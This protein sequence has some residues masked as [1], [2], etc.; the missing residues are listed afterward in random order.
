M[1]IFRGNHWSQMPNREETIRKDVVMALTAAELQ[2]VTRLMDKFVVVWQ[3][4]GEG[5]D[6]CRAILKRGDDVDGLSIDQK[7][8]LIVRAKALIGA[9]DAAN[10]DLKTLR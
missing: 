6:F 7:R 3:A 1:S 8:N 5:I 2:T 9:V 4:G 10:T